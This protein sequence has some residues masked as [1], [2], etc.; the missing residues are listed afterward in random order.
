MTTADHCPNMTA[1]EI[2]AAV[3]NSLPWS[4]YRPACGGFMLVRA[5]PPPDPGG[6]Y[7]ISCTWVA[8]KP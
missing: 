5:V 7:A 3:K 1:A 8:S 4:W 6:Y 2:E